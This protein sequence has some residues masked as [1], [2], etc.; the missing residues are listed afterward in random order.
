MEDKIREPTLELKVWLVAIEAAIK[1]ETDN[2]DGQT[3]ISAIFPK[4]S[5]D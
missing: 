3:W 2:I 1:R 4:E 5:D